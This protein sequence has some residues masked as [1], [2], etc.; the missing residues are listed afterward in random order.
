MDATAL[1]LMLI[2]AFVFLAG[3]FNWSWV[4]TGTN[5]RWVVR[6]LGPQGARVFHMV[7]GGVLIVVGALAE[8]GMISLGS[9]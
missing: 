6:L 8:M 9:S 1:I 2:G 3:F 5:A 7:V 4:M